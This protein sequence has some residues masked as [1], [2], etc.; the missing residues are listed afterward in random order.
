M[1]LKEPQEEKHNNKQKMCNKSHIYFI[2]DFLL[3]P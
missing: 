1:L 3:V 2:P